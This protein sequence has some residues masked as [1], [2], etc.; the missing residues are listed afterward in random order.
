[1]VGKS[2]MARL[3]ESTQGPK[4]ENREDAVRKAYAL[5]ENAFGSDDYFSTYEFKRGF[6]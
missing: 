6:G 4:E 1:M 2:L 3:A 5:A